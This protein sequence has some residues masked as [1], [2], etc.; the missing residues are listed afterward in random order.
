ML[1][2]LQIQDTLSLDVKISAAPLGK[3]RSL[4]RSLTQLLQFD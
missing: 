1:L 3:S 4:I 2:K